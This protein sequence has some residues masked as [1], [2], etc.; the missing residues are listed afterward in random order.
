MKGLQILSATAA[1]FMLIVLLSGCYDS[2]FEPY[3]VL[4]VRE[5]YPVG[6]VSIGY[7]FLSERREQSC[8][9]R[10]TRVNSEGSIY[11]DQRRLPDSGVLEFDG[12]EAGSYT[13]YFAVLSEKGPRSTVIPFLEQSHNFLVR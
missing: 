1:V 4:D 6:T 13:L 9:Y 11:T 7:S 3:L 12:L 8:M 5:E 2:S 10:L